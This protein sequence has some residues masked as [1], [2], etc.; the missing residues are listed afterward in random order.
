MDGNDLSVTEIHMVKLPIKFSP[1]I[2]KP[3]SVEDHDYMIYFLNM[4]ARLHIHK[5]LCHSMEQ[6]LY[7]GLHL[8]NT[9]R[10]NWPHV[11]NISI[12]VTQQFER[13]SSIRRLPIDSYCIVTTYQ[14]IG[15]NKYEESELLL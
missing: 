3:L 5:L 11:L 4:C 9:R 7:D 12:R 15:M 1:T 13:Q 14:F 10:T 2:Y 8:C 6:K